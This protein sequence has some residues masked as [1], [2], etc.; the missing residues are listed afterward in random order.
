MEVF[1][2]EGGEGDGE[3]GGGRW[4][5][6]ERAGEECVVVCYVGDGWEWSV[7]LMDRWWDGVASGRS[8]GGATGGGG[9]GASCGCAKGMLARGLMERLWCTVRGRSG[10]VIE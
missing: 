9:L 10:A 6:W 7:W 3:G 2:P 8:S 4:A 1:L 5:G